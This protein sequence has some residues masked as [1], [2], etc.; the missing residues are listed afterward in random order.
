MKNDTQNCIFFFIFHKIC[1]ELNQPENY[2]AA[3]AV[4]TVAAATAAALI[5]IGIGSG[6][7]HDWH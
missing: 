1:Q 6:I 4:A 3:F 2:T 5:D 7:D